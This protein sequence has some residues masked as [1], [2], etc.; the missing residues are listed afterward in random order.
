MIFVGLE[1]LRMVNVKIF[2]WGIAPR[3]M[4]LFLLGY[5]FDPKDG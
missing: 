5:S 3:N 4:M 2:F 1:V